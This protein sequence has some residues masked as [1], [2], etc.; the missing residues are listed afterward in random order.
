MKSLY[1]EAKKIAFA[2]KLLKEW[3]SII[4]KQNGEKDIVKI[5]LNLK[6]KTII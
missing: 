3:E 2:I 1:L 6:P 4:F 5:E